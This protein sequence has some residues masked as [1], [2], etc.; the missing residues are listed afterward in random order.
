MGSKRLL[1]AETMTDFRVLTAS[2]PKCS[3]HLQSISALSRCIHTCEGQLLALH[4]AAAKHIVMLCMM[5]LTCSDV[6]S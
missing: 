4:L 2:C 6:Q 5:L 3:I 1:V